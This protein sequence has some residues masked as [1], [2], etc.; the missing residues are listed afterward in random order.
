MEGPKLTMVSL[1]EGGESRDSSLDQTIFR[2]KV[3]IL[4]WLRL[5]REPS[6]LAGRIVVVGPSECRSNLISRDTSTA[7]ILTSAPPVSRC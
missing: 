2:L 1:V 5:T 4:R 3:D 7:A 6:R